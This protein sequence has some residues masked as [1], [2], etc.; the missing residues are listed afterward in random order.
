MILLECDWCH[1]FF[2]PCCIY[3]TTFNEHFLIHHQ[4]P[5]GG[6][7]RGAANA[8]KLIGF[9]HLIKNYKSNRNCSQ[10]SHNGSSMG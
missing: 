10:S 9:K 6:C 5:S 4:C 1:I 8:D 3:F 7:D 2:E